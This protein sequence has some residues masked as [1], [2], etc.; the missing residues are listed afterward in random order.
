MVK[1]IVIMQINVKTNDCFGALFMDKFGEVKGE[2]E[3]YPPMFLPE[4]PTDLCLSIDLET[5][6]ILN[7]TKP[8]PHQI[9]DML[10]G[11]EKL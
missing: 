6:K 3:G 5:G 8:L 11:G 10:D 4:G 2:Y 1:G 7:W 9:E